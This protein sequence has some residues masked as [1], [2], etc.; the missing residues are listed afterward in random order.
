MLS[1]DSSDEPRFQIADLGETQLILGVDA[2]GGSRAGLGGGRPRHRL[3]DA[4]SLGDPG[5][6]LPGPGAPQ[7]LSDLPPRRRQVVKLPPDKGEGQ[8][9][10]RKPGKLY[11]AP[12]WIIGTRRPDE[13][14]G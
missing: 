6:A 13:V 11:S 3:S 1:T 12:R 2:D 4:G 10:N 5:R 7:P 14:S 8:Q 9:W